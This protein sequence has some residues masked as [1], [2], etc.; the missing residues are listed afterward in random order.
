[1]K[2][3]DAKLQSEIDCTQ[4]KYEADKASMAD[5]EAMAQSIQTR[6]TELNALK[7]KTKTDLNDH[8]QKIADM[9]APMDTS[10]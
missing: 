6:K 5:L 2:A 10:L 4:A 3:I 9:I 7:S 1:M 8:L